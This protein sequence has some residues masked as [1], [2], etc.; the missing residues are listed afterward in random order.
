MRKLVVLSLLLGVLVWAGAFEPT[1]AEAYQ[2][3]TVYCQYGA[4]LRCCTN[5]TC[6]TSPG[7]LNCDGTVVTCAA[8]DTWRACLDDCYANYEDCVTTCDSSQCLKLCSDLR[9]LCQRQICGTAPQTN[10]GC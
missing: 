7:T 9:S 8:S 5:G 10:F 1:P 2:T 4:S 6:S 3:C